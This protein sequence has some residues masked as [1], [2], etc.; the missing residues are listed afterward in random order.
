MLFYVVQRT[1]EYPDIKTNCLA[2]RSVAAEGVVKAGF[3]QWTAR[4]QKLS[5]VTKAPW[6]TEEELGEEDERVQWGWGS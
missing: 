2:G 4:W 1:R 5:A 3:E 6:R